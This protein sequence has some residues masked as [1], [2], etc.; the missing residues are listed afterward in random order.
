V[1]QP[2]DEDGAGGEAPAEPS[3]EVNEY[4]FEPPAAFEFVSAELIAYVAVPIVLA[5]LALGRCSG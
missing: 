5:L 2:G 1:S 4:R 3:W